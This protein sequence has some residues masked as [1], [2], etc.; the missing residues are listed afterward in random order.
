MSD[1]YE[2]LE[3]QIN[4]QLR[5]T[6]DKDLRFF[7]VEEYLRMTKRVEDFAS[8]CR[9]C[10]SFKYEIEKTAGDIG[11]AI[12]SPGK[13]RRNYDRLMGNL[14]KHMRKQHGFYPP[15]YFTYLLAFVYAF[16][17]SVGAFIVSLPFVHLDKWFFIVPAFIIGLVLGNLRGAKK[18]SRIR[19]SEKLL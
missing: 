14:S 13:T 7:R 2:K 9:E 17:A 19:N 10:N 1:W 12:A 4:D 18:D 16:G 11:V 8:S 6:R 3:A 15:Y 5:D